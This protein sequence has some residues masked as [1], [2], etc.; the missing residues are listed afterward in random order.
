MSVWELQNTCGILQDL[1]FFA[2]H[3]QSLIAS[4]QQGFEGMAL[5]TGL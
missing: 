1:W 2:G 4:D 5:S 3:Q